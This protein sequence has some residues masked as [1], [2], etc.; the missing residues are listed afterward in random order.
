MGPTV[1]EIFYHRPYRSIIDR[2]IQPANY[3]RMGVKQSWKQ[4]QKKP[5]RASR[6]EGYQLI[7]VYPITVTM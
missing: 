4:T 6:G 1:E 7:I 5:L 2:L 3:N